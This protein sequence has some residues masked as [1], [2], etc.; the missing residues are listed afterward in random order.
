ME[1]VFFSLWLRKMPNIGSLH[2]WLL[3]PFRVVI[4]QIWSSITCNI[5]S[6]FKWVFI[7]DDKG[8]PA[9]SYKVVFDYLRYW[10][11]WFN[12]TMRNGFLFDGLHG[13]NTTTS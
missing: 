9:P 2:V 11:M 4:S 8:I 6:P 10:G 13:G 12:W 7:I 5:L 1:N 3:K